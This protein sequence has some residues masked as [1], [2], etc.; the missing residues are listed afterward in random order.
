ML[1]CDFIVLAGGRSSRMGEDKGLLKIY[2]LPLLVKMLKKISYPFQNVI[3]VCS[4]EKQKLRYLEMLEN[5][6]HGVSHKSLHVIVDQSHDDK[7]ASYGIRAGLIKSQAECSLVTTVDAAGVDTLMVKKLIQE[8]AKKPNSPCAFES[9]LQGLCP[10]P[11]LFWKTHLDKIPESANSIKG[12]L[13]SFSKLHLVEAD[14]VEADLL[15]VNLNTPDDVVNFYGKPLM[16]PMNR[17]INYLRLSL[18]EVCNMKC[19][20]CVS[21]EYS[22]E[23][24][25]KQMLSNDSV[26]T[27]LESF[28]RLGFE[29]IRFTGGEPFLH[30]HLL[31]TI[32]KARRLGYETISITTNASIAKDIVPYIEAGLTHINISLDSLNEANFYDITKSR[33]FHSVMKQIDDSVAH[34]LNVKV[35]TVVLKDRN[36]SEVEDFIKWAKQLPL[37]LRFIE[38]MPVDFHS[39]KHDKRFISN[40]DVKKQ[41]LKAGYRPSNRLNT[42]EPAG[43]AVLF[44]HPE[45]PGRIALISPLTCSFCERCNRVRVTATGR[46]RL[47]LFSKGDIG[48]PLESGPEVVDDFVRLAINEK[49]QRLLLNRDDYKN[50]NELRSIGG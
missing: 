20:Y 36:Y 14:P 10:F 9:S 27:V 49:E 33:R 25:L 47:C 17:R 39:D 44:D 24:D 5:Y 50:I 43:P 37:T 8:A 35:N 19:D 18:T 45:Y 12:L 46:L 31:T 30:P 4:T 16:D 40:E 13:Q 42:Y 41:L 3:V 32:K 7:A 28:R 26:D 29:K 6:Q 2:G 34:G 1:N 21:E 15:N 22:G 38:V 11:S 48:L 23:V